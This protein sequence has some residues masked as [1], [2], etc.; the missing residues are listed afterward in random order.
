MII[1]PNCVSIADESVKPLD[2][3]FGV[4]SYF[5]RDGLRAVNHDNGQRQCSRSS[6]LS[7]G[8]LPA[9]VFRNDNVNRIAGQ[10]IA[11]R[12]FRKRRTGKDNVYIWRQCSLT[13]WWINRPSNIRVL[14][15]SCKRSEVETAER[16]ENPLSRLT[17]SS[18]GRGHIWNA[19]PPVLRRLHPCRTSERDQWDAGISACVSCVLRDLRGKWMRCVDDHSN[20]LLGNVIRKSLYAAETASARFDWLNFWCFG[21]ASQRDSRVITRIICNE[22]RQLTRFA[23]TAKDEDAH[24]RTCT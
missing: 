11:L 24:V 8:L 13:T 10:E 9:R 17:K 15:R 12:R 4:L 3:V 2:N 20:P 5:A 19:Y 21:S 23:G 7:V 18:N 22:P 6:N 1:S 16:Q 14:R